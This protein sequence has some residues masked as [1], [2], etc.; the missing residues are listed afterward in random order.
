VITACGG[1]SSPVAA[2]SA[3]AT[4]PRP[5]RTIIRNTHVVHPGQAVRLLA[6]R[7]VALR[8]R[9]T[10]PR[11]RRTRLSSTHG[12]PPA[13]GYYVTFRVT[14]VNIGRKP[15]GIGPG[16]FATVVPG[17]G[18]VT[19]YEGNAP[20]SGA[21]R[22]LDPT[23]LAPGDS[24]RAPLTFDVSKPHGRFGYYPDRSPAIIWVY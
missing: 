7:G 12:Y 5:V 15:I 3:T 18:R 8:L 19:S 1:S 6:Q 22:Q 24:V 2:P 23:E 11:V 13:H 9:A 17:E 10:G 20:Y 14:V 21:A 16:D 4:T